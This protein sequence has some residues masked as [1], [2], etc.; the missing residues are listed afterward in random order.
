MPRKVTNALTALT[1]KAA[2]P[3]RHADGGGLHLLVK[4]TGA[5]SWVFRFMLQGKSRDVGL[6][7]ASGQ[8]A[9]KLS[10]ARDLA[11]ALRLKVK[12]GVDPLDERDTLAAK[13]LAAAQ[14]AKVAGYSF[15]A[16][17]GAYIATN[18]PSWRNAKHRQQWANTLTTYVYP[19]IG[20]M[21][22]SQVDTAH[23]LSILEPIWEA[24]PETASRVR[25]R[26]E[27]ILDSA[28]AR[29][30]REGGN[31]A[32]WRGHI[33]QI[34]P[35]RTRLSRGHHRALPYES[36]PAFVTRLA[37][38]KAMA[39]LAL[40]F[41][42]LT[43]ARTGEVIGATWSELDLAKAIWTIPAARMK[44]GKEHRVP[45]SVRALAILEK[46]KIDGSDFLFTGDSGG[47]LSGMAMTMLLRRMDVDCTAHG[48]RSG[49]RDWAA[50]RTA[51]AHEVCEMALAHVIGN[52][53]EAAY[54]RGDLFEKRR[55]LMD[56]WAAY[57]VG[58]GAAGAKVTPIRGAAA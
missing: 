31:P 32:R 25:G 20:D 49:F 44:A 53:A 10:E 40:E 30:Y 33:A 21:P 11:A 43:A 38:R 34:L 45:L 36:V 55:R 51:Y 9:I 2:S 24:K 46:A 23:V 54:R 5:R 8:D 50:E 28:K 27:T 6:G 16:A 29:G 12:A 52:K 15:R 22:V 1:V 7:P 57:C 26:I 56:D 4:T 39:A 48:F 19:V 18:E 47:K 3:G 41:T 42:I 14:A 35:P 58:D 17:G 37:D 13:A